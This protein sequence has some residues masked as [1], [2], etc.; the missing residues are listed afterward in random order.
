MPVR[1]YWPRDISIPEAVDVSV[2][3]LGNRF[4]NEIVRQLAR[5]ERAQLSGLLELTGIQRPTLGAHLRELEEWGVISVDLAPG[6][7]KGKSVNYSL[8]KA[9]VKDIVSAHL[10]FLVGDSPSTNHP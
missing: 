1:D 6:R 5:V 9:R 3:V 8:N 4:N 2:A 10:D 7:R